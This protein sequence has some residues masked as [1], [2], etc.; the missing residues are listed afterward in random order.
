MDIYTTVKS[1][2]ALAQES[3]LA[4][5]RLLVRHGDAGLAAGEIARELSI[6]HNT[7]S[8]HLAILANAG[9]V[10]SRRESRSIIYSIDFGGTRELL[11]F[12]MQDCCQ[13]LPEICA[14]VL[15]SLL[16][17][18][19]ASTRQNGENHETHAR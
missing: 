11:S 4:A 12:L 7:M 19:C 13:G 15:D 18:C 1:L 5:F 6:P 16:P 10:N 14:P 17:G 8:S 2:G 3:R 9:L